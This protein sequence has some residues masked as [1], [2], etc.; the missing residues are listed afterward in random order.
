MPPF[1][2]SLRR[3]LEFYLTFPLLGLFLRAGFG[4]QF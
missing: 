4:S 1:E 2:G 3:E